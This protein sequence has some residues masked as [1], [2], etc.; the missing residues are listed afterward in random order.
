MKNPLITVIVPVCNVAK[1]LRRCLDS[2]ISQTYQ[3]LEIICV[4]DGSTDHSSEICEQYA[5]KDERVKVFHQ[6]NQGV[7][8]ARNKGLDMVAGEYITFVDSDDYIQSDMLERLYSELSKSEASYVICGYNVVNS[9]G[10]V[11]M[12]CL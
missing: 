1:Y 7:S 9:A 10:I 12:D 3:N 4:D 11:L 6:E 2:V 5:L 8:A